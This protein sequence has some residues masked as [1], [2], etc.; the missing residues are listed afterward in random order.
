MFASPTKTADIERVCQPSADDFMAESRDTACEMLKW[1]AD[2][3][4]Q[5]IKSE[6]VFAQISISGRFQAYLKHFSAENTIAP[7]VEPGLSSIKVPIQIVQAAKDEFCP[8]I[9]TSRLMD[10]I[11]DAVKRYTV[12]PDPEATHGY[13]YDALTDPVLKEL[14]IDQLEYSVV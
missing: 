11:G 10:E 7:L 1:M 12:A 2:F 9:A 14:L 6:E 8:V 3:E 4:G 5:P 13:F